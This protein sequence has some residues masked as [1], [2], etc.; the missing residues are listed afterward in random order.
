[1]IA[2]KE[3]IAN[4]TL[5]DLNF[6]DPKIMLD[7][8]IESKE[9]VNKILSNNIPNIDEADT[10]NILEIYINR[11]HCRNIDSNEKEKILIR[12]NILTLCFHSLANLIVNKYYGDVIDERTKK[13]N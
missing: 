11:E 12:D 8:V 2:E 5:P 10:V 13:Y 7:T 6:L 9:E 1:M 3:R 4:S